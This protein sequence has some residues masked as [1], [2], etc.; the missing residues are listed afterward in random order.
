MS[1]YLYFAKK[2]LVIHTG[3]SVITDIGVT[4]EAKRPNNSHEMIV[5]TN[6]NK[7]ALHKLVSCL[8]AVKAGICIAFLRC[9]LPRFD[10]LGFPLTDVPESFTIT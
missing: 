4:I 5:A 3:K 1:A 8:I 7:K 9:L 2:D 10:I 6:V